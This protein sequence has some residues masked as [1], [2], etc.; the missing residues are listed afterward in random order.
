ME[1]LTAALWDMMQVAARVDMTVDS[2]D[3]RSAYSLGD[4]MAWRKGKIM[5]VVTAG[6]TALRSVET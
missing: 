6:G 4:W 5:V 1:P 2:W 3:V